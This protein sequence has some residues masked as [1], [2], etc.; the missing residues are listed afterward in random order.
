[1]LK[2]EKMQVSGFK[3]F[4]DRT[5]IRFPDGITAVVGPNGCGKSN[6]GDAINWVLGEQS[7]KNLRGKQMVDV[8]FN[9]SRG[10]KPKGMAEVSLYLKNDDSN[11]PP[12]RQ[13]IVLTRKLFRS[14]ESEYFLNGSR[15]RLKVI[16]EILRDE[17]VGAKTYATIEQ[18][19]IDQI[20]NAKPKERRLIIEDAAGISG[21]KHKRR[22]AEL[23][24]ESTHA[25]L[26]R[27]NDIIVEVTR[28]INSLKRQAAKARRYQR[29][30]EELRT[31]E[32]TLFGHRTRE[33]DN[34]FGKL[35]DQEAVA[36]DQEAASAAGLSRA[37]ASLSEERHA[38]DE[39]DRVFRQAAESLHQLD[40][41]ID[42]EESAIRHA[43]DRIN[44]ADETATLAADEAGRL[45]GRQEE[46]RARADEH[47]IVVEQGARQIEVL[48]E[49]LAACQ[50]E[51]AGLAERQAEGREEQEQH[52]R[53]LFR[54]MNQGAEFRNRK[55]SLEESL[56]RTGAER[57]VL[58]GELRRASADHTRLTEESSDLTREAHDHRENLNRLA[59]Q[60]AR[61]ED[62]LAAIRERL[63]A[64]VEELAAGRAEAQSATARL[65]TLED[66]ATRFAGV[67]DGVRMLLTTGSAAGM[68]THGV[69]ADY[70]EAGKDIEAAAEVYL[71]GVLPAVILEDGADAR[72]AVNMLRSEGAGR[73]T[74][75][76]RSQPVGGTAV[77]T[78]AN[79][80]SPVP[81]E[82][83]ADP[84][85]VGRL[86]HQ[87]R[88][89][90]SM[91]GVVQDRIGDA[92][93]VDSLETALEL[94]ARFPAS[95]YLTR[96][97]EV[98]YASGLVSAG[99]DG[100]AEHGLLAHNRQANETR[101]SLERIGVE[102]ARMEGEVQAARDDAA[103]LEAQ[104]RAGRQALEEAGRRKV[105]LDLREQRAMEEEQKSSRQGDVLKSEVAN[106]L[107]AA[108]QLQSELTEK[109][110]LVHEAEQSHADLEAKM[111]TRAEELTSLEAVLQE[112]N[113]AAAQHRAELAAMGQ[114]QE[115]SDREQQRLD[116]SLADLGA[117]I[118][119]HRGE[120]DKA[121]VRSTEARE[122]VRTTEASL[123][124][125]LAIRADKDGEVK[126]MESSI[127]ERR[128]VLSGSEGGLHG[129]KTELDRLR[130]T[131]R[132]AEME[133]T[134]AESD[135]THLDELCQGELGCSAADALSLLEE[136]EGQAS[137]ETGDGEKL[138]LDLVKLGEEVDEIREKIEKI[139][140]V[141]M[142]AIDEFSE[143]EERHTFLTA[144]KEDLTQSM[145]SLQETIKKINRT[146][147]ERFATAFE[148]IRKN[149]QEIFAVL[150]SG[151]RA[152]L[153]M[154][155][156]EDI[157]E[158]GIEIMAQ[159]PGKRL[160][161]VNLMSG[162]EKAMSA[163]ALLFAIFRFRP[164]PFCLLDEVDA[165]LDDANVARFTK[166]V[167]EYAQHT[168]FILVTHNKVSMEAANL[169]YGVT[170]EEPGVSK[171]ISLQMS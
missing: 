105:E 20:L 166:M 15:S 145:A 144:Q 23:K 85:V 117:R 111:K 169:L 141:N 60:Q 73:T 32:R 122:L 9:G 68:K 55:K 115:S 135:R 102:V 106:L 87:I 77:G 3:S 83:L 47:R 2:L 35:K 66:V 42:R 12:D 112:K 124:E 76:C 150:F 167:A 19:R 125:H 84:R 155:E 17:H 153:H 154:E 121:R 78:P 25:N 103:A 65:R 93:V 108:E 157:L 54:A 75:L 67:S 133:R 88:L 130:E 168:Q 40:M 171:L 52:R 101:D 120:A 159:P 43:R 90:T 8:I 92:V 11:L 119:G 160:G 72:L 156:G 126:A 165:A 63:A 36:R 123:T 132:L 97:G 158:S 80:S 24:L 5:E 96:E 51:L 44:E 16:Q 41:E 28:Q 138:P 109:S 89:N 7:P 149:Y 131:T 94:H 79:G 64:G 86:K 127:A 59:L 151:G 57:A 10:K 147:R 61:R 129:L 161:S 136:E 56:T 49:R 71:Q 137:E 164:S 99:G 134:K 46:I 1:M 34:R 6:L 69:V 29:L 110:R 30:R 48:R 148:A 163:I 116:E 70:V 26:L 22:L 38:L 37:E 39:A 62:S 95:D 82:I 81:G 104:V 50:T 107:Q 139:G 45:T 74:F 152:D 162:G 170:M 13:R 58:D 146:S 27:V 21:I 14:G 31:K 4:S 140:P 143:L 118:A 142:M 91:N 128:L 18:G 98:V 33:M 113:E 53:D 114:Q 100:S